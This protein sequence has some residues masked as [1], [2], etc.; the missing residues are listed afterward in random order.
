MCSPACLRHAT[1]VLAGRYSR[2]TLVEIWPGWRSFHQASSDR[3]PLAL[4]G[5]LPVLWLLLSVMSPGLC[6][7]PVSLTSSYPGQCRV[8]G[9]RATDPR[10]IHTPSLF[11]LGSS[12]CSS[13]K[14]SPFLWL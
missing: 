1:G 5:D 4:A 14:V 2:C 9:Q 3:L 11:L 10:M 6:V 13:E 7:P 8:T 12:G